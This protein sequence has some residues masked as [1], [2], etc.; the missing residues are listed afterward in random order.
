MG[1][2]S[3]NKGVAKTYVFTSSGADDGVE[4]AIGN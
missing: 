4:R 2:M 3:G 1:W